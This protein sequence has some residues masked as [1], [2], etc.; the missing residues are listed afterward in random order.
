MAVYYCFCVSVSKSVQQCRVWECVCS[1]PL[2]YC[3][4]VTALMNVLMVLVALDAYLSH[5]PI[6]A[7]LSNCLQSTSVG[8]ALQ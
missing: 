8:R 7:A 2:F 5:S 4:G 1:E 6:R 3:T